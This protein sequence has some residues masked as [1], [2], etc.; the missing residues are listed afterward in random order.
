[1]KWLVFLGLSLPLLLRA[2]PNTQNNKT[3]LIYCPLKGLV[4]VVNNSDSIQYQNQML[5]GFIDFSDFVEEFDTLTISASIY[6]IALPTPNQYTGSQH[7]SIGIATSNKFYEGTLSMNHLGM[8]GFSGWYSTNYG[9]MQKVLLG[10]PSIALS[11][12]SNNQSILS[13]I[14]HADTAIISDS[15]VFIDELVNAGWYDPRIITIHK[16]NHSY[17]SILW[18]FDLTPI[19]TLYLPDSLGA[20]TQNVSFVESTGNHSLVFQKGNSIRVVEQISGYQDSFTITSTYQVDSAK[21]LYNAYSYFTYV[22][23]TF[24]DTTVLQN[25]YYY[26]P[27][28]N[29]EYVIPDKFDFLKAIYHPI[30][31]EITQHRPY[32]FLWRDSTTSG[33]Y[34]GYDSGIDSLATIKGT[35]LDMGPVYLCIAGT[36]PEIAGQDSQLYPN[37]ARD[38]LFYKTSKHSSSPYQ[39]EIFN[40]NGM[41]IRTF[42]KTA[43][44]KDLEISLSGLPNGLLLIRLTHDNF[45]ETLKVVHQ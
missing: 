7:Q 13:T 4:A 34:A 24:G 39:I 15:I 44:N 40:S 38:V 12:I 30:N 3:Q 21:L 23:T 1:M 8:T 18:D 35:L 6:T 16:A 32:R 28:R 19:D 31:E 33:I 14:P 10:N 41:L 42:Q 11:A 22:D 26:E 9:G 36:V 2:Q 20:F 29:F 45:T 27:S 5:V 25:I 17:V 43:G 37:P